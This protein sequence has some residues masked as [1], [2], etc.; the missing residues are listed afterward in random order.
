MSASA[1]FFVIDRAAVSDLTAAADPA[2]GTGLYAVA[3]AVGHDLDAAAEGAVFP[4]SGYCFVFLMEFLADRGVYSGSEFAE[5]ERL[6]S[7]PAGVGAYLLTPE[8]F[9]DLALLD[10]D[11]YDESDIRRYFDELGVGF[12]EA[13]VAGKDGITGLAEHV[14]AL[15]SDQA[16]LVLVG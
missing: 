16:L 4:W 9:T 5:A 3:H 1:S 8:S 7:S 10:P 12:A 2:P 13:G 11:R 6:L 15:D 14:G